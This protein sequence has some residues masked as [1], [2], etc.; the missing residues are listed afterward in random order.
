LVFL[1]HCA[2]FTVSFELN[3]SRY[4]QCRYSCL[5]KFQTEAAIFFSS[6]SYYELSA[7]RDGFFLGVIL[8]R[9]QWYK[10]SVVFM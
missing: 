3:L 5:Q 8:C 2:F 9:C 4:K 7:R 1:R 10:C 6:D